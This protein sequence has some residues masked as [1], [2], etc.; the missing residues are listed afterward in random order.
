MA[1]KTPVVDADGHVC[2]PTELWQTYLESKYRDRA[3][4]FKKDDRGREHLV[5]DGR[6]CAE[7]LVGMYGL[8]SGL[9]SSDYEAL[10]RKGYFGYN[11]PDITHPGAY[12]PKAR[13]EIMN[14]QGIDIAYIYPTLGLFWDAHITD[15][16]LGAACARAYNNWALDFCSHDPNRLRPIAHTPL[17]DADEAVQELQRLAKLGVPGVFIGPRAYNNG[18]PF[19]GDP[20]Y[21]KFWATAQDLDIPVGIHITFPDQFT[22]DERSPEKTHGFPSRG[23][24]TLATIGYPVQEAFTGLIC[25]MVFDRFPRLKILLLETTASWLPN[26]LERMDNKFNGLTQMVLPLSMKPSEYFQRQCWIGIDSDEKVLASVVPMIGADKLLFASDFPHADA[27]IDPVTEAEE[28]LAPLSRETK[29]RI[30]G[31]NVLDVY[32]A[33]AHKQPG[34]ETEV[35]H[36]AA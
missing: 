29:E 18:H 6:P 21:D 20:Y 22:M 24:F 30:L 36:S 9:G 19:I 1:G 26:W 12:E 27:H 32:A 2:E 7:A 13:L 34:V 35:A 14:K 15:G 11:D 4:E 23:L 28:S 25:A 10:F 5:M 17:F 8:F 3:V 16:K 31:G 33:S